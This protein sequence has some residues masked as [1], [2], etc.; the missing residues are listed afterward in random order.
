ME[1]KA[2]IRQV[3]MSPRKIRVVANQVRGQRV[4]ETLTQLG[5]MPKKAAGIIA[6]AV[7]SAAANAEDK[8]GGTADL[9]ALVIKTIM[10][11]GA[12]MSKRFMPRAMGRANRINH[13]ASHLT[14]VVSDEE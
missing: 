8:S 3:S 4:G 7:T 1:A 13:R 5:F 14:V 11:D 6:K 12:R 2:I 10:I 9:D